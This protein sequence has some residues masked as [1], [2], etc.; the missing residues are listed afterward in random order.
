LVLALADLLDSLESIHLWHLD[1]HGD[2]VWLQSLHLL[3]SYL[4]IACSADHF[5]FGV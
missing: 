1:I 2:Y 4:A 5:N 3:D